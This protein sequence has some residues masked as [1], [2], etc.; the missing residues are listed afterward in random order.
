MR[1][2]T[3]IG[4]LLL[5]LLPGRA[6][7]GPQGGPKLSAR[8]AAGVVRLGDTGAV[9]LTVEDGRDARILAVPEVAG[10]RFGRPS[11]PRLRQSTSYINGRLSSES[12]LTIVL[13][14]RAEAEG[15]H[16]IPPIALEIDGRRQE[17]RALR[18]TVVRDITGADFGYVEVRPTAQRVVEGQPFTV[19]IR[20]GWLA[21][22]QVNFA[23]LNLPWWDSLPGAI[24]LAERTIPQESRVDGILVNGRLQ[25]AAEQLDPAERKGRS[26]LTLRLTKTFLPTRSGPLEFP[27]SF[28][29]FGVRRQGLFDARRDSHFVEAAPFAVEVVELPSEGQPLDFSGAV[30]T[31]AA[32][33]S[34]DLRDVRAGD[35]IKL[36]VEWTGQGNLEFF[37]AP[38]PGAL[39]AF[40]GFRA[41]GSTEEKRPE[42]RTVVYD[43]APLSSEV[44]AIPSLPLAVYD[45][46]AARYVTVATEPIPIRVRP[47][48]RAAALGDD[49]RRF[50]RDIADIDARAPAPARTGGGPGQDRFLATA[51]VVVPLLGLLARAHVRRRGGD[52]GAP[53]ERR[54]RRAARAL[55]RALQGAAD[56]AAAQ[57]AWLEFLA[58]RTREPAAAWNGRDFARWAAEHAPGLE[59]ELARAAGAAQADLEAAVWGGAPAPE[60]ARL[61]ELGRRLA[62]AGL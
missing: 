51:L 49:E 26:F 36:T 6:A 62:E 45:P 17:T 56:P 35:S 27:T 8:L 19:E 34:A 16:E 58:A 37:R 12:T 41:Y 11:E 47:L 38:D 5:A 18:V 52:P 46:V 10:L 7:A 29:E 20:F 42:R 39:D 50:E 57:A 33:A 40:R 61:V 9:N 3:T 53:L 13:P 15:D 2:R 32:R 22:E 31:L 60:R 54:R 14:F 43:L 24:E 59:G 44:E 48:E 21:S 23:E 25:V 55:G 4:L 30:G 1:T 28:F